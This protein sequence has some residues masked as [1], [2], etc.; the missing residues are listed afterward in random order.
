MSPEH[1]LLLSMMREARQFR[2]QPAARPQPPVVAPVMPLAPAG[3]ATP[4]LRQAVEA[5]AKA[6]GSRLIYRADLDKWTL[7]KK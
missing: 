5:V 3:E 6:T 4:G 2:P 1:A 7:S